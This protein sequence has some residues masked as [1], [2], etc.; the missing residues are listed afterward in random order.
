MNDRFLHVE[1]IEAIE[2]LH[3][4]RETEGFLYIRKEYE[5]FSNRLWNAREQVISRKMSGVLL[6]GQPGI[7]RYNKKHFLSI[8]CPLI[9]YYAGKS[10]FLA[11]FLLECMSRGEIVLFT[12]DGWSYL[13]D[14]SGVMY[15]GTK[16]ITS[17]DL[18]RSGRTWSL[19]DS[20]VKKEP[21]PGNVTYQDPRLFFV[22]ALSPD[23]IRYKEAVKFMAVKWWMDVWKS[24]EIFAL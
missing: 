7:G 12:T 16:T 5:A 23:N 9:K 20:P 3:I 21:I 19:L 2:D 4:L 22:A 8:L 13:I 6:L 1:Q 24:E 18:P 11:F 10:F 17:L 14:E 15:K